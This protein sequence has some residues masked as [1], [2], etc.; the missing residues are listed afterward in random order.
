MPETVVAPEVHKKLDPA[1]QEMLGKSMLETEANV[2]PVGVVEVETIDG[3]LTS[4]DL[5]HDVFGTHQHD[6]ANITT[7]GEAFALDEVGGG[8]ELLKKEHEEQLTQELAEAETEALNKVDASTE[9]VGPAVEANMAA[10]DAE[11]TEIR[12]NIKASLKN[13]TEARRVDEEAMKRAL[14]ESNV[15]VEG[16]ASEQIAHIAAEGKENGSVQ[17]IGDETVASAQANVAEALEDVHS[18]AKGMIG[19]AAEDVSEQ[20][21]D[22]GIKTTAEEIE[23]ELLKSTGNDEPNPEELGDA[24]EELEGTRLVEAVVDNKNAT[25]D[26]AKHLGEMDLSQLKPLAEAV[27][28]QRRDGSMSELEKRRAA[29]VVTDA[30]PESKQAA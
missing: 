24:V 20:L 26:L 11:V 18:D 6:E 5:E 29:K 23:T 15:E 7:D 8:G 22:L 21:N 30:N 10:H 2:A 27:D 17:K 13:D 9:G 14:E 25:P 3:Q 4:D 12:N 1:V 19:D 16:K 28:F